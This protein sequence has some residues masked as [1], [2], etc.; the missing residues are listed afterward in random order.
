MA[1]LSA[2]YPKY[3]SN[4][5]AR[6]ADQL[7]DLCLVPR[8]HSLMKKGSPGYLRI[9]RSSNQT[10][11]MKLTDIPLLSC[12]EAIER[13][14]QN[15]EN[16]R[17]KQQFLAM[18]S[19]IFGG[20]VTDEAAMVIP[21]DDHMVHRG[22]VHLYEL[23]QHVDRILRSATMSKIALP[24]G[25]E[26]I[27]SILIQT[28]SASRCM[29]GSLRY[30]ISAGPGD[31]QLSPSGCHQP[32]LY[33]VVIEDKSPFD[34][35]GIK[36][37]TSSIPIKPPQ[38]A[39]VKSVNYLPN[40]LSK[41][42]AE[43]Q[44]AFAAIWLD[45]DGFIAEGPNMNVAFVTKKKELL[46]PRFNKILSGCTAKRVLTLAE[47]LVRQ[48]TLH[49]I[50]VDNVSVDEGKSADEM[51]LIGSG[52]L[53]RPVIQWDGQVIGDG[54]EGP[55]SKTLLNFILEDMKSGPSSVRVKDVVKGIKKKIKS[56]HP[57]VQILALTLLECML[58]NCGDI[59]HVH[60]ADRNVLPE[61]VKIYKKRSDCGVKEKILLLVDTW[62]EDF[63]GARAV[64]PHYFIAYQELLRAGAVFPQRNERSQT[65]PKITK[66]W[67]AGISKS[68]TEIENVRRI[69]NDL[70]DML[71]ALDPNNKEGVKQDDIVDLVEQ[72]RT[73][74]QR[75]LHLVNSTSDESLL[76]QGLDLN[77]DLQHLLAKHQ[78]IASGSS[79]QPDNNKPK[80]ARET[81]NS[82][83]HLVDTGD[84][85]NQSIARSISGADA[86]SQPGNTAPAAATPKIDLL[87]CNDFDSS[88]ADISPAMVPFGEAQETSP[89]PQQ[90]ATVPYDMFPDG[91]NSYD[92]S[93]T[94][95]LAG[96]TNPWTP[97]FQQQEQNFHGII[98]PT[99]NS[100]LDQQQPS[101]SPA[102]ALPPPPWEAQ[103]A[104]CSLIPGAKYPQP[105]VSTYTQPITTGHFSA[106][107]NNRAMQGSQFASFHPQ[108]S[109][110]P[111][112][113]GMV[114]Y[115]Q[116][117]QQMY[118]N[119]Q[120]EA[121]SDYGQ[122]QYLD[123][124]M[125]GLSIRDDNGLINSPYQ[126]SSASNV[127]PSKS[128]QPTTTPGTPGTM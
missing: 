72:C 62:Q 117:E 67:A 22:M 17:G 40:V 106:T 32:A 82:G 73:Y 35:R 89:A 24:I 30:W 65:Q 118:G 112:Y 23:D 101:P 45:T 55:I 29:N 31:F 66:I 96:Q 116:Q 79:Y 111:Q 9:V 127:L 58:K 77:E 12:L 109:Q 126:V 125:N 7:Y 21:M 50:R 91:N 33:A 27:R 120:M 71:N 100:Q 108:Q 19:S 99:W 107:N 63:G 59:V 90:K 122:Q 47:E 94:Q 119:P 104:D 26:T 18:Y 81:G 16:N 5:P 98:G 57:K 93:N 64:Y 10:E 102:Y 123:Q 88:N 4:F 38:F 41:M 76:R 13:L 68:S 83:G 42:E 34:S 49:R 60:V 15:R 121:P 25:R 14:K 37:V 74:K 110:E 70:A 113:M 124:Q 54:K 103:P 80:P 87:S 51:M 128:S 20:I 95:G 44:G 46:M 97:Q 52:I 115:N 1:S 56:K 2:T 8:N 39:T 11:S 36:V 86:S 92:S 85:S 43:E 84:I 61:M 53:V 75:V 28:V 3:K 6:Y 78:A 48:G 105:M 114:P 69:I